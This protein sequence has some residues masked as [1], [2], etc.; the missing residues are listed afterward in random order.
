MRT[1]LILYAYKLP[2][3]CIQIFPLFRIQFSFLPLRLSQDPYHNRFLSHLFHTVKNRRN[4]KNSSKQI[5]EKE[6]D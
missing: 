5:P 2:I 3:V 1:K 6:S 4:E